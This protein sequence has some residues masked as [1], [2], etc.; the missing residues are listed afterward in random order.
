MINMMRT[1]FMLLFVASFTSL[2]AQTTD[3]LK[4]HRADTTFDVVESP[5]EF[6]GWG[7]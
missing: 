1:L 4:G 7:G 6:P 2:K 3:T 5:P